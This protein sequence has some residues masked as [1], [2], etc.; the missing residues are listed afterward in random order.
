[1]C[2]IKKKIINLQLN[3]IR[4]LFKINN[5]LSTYLEF[6][7]CKFFFFNILQYF[8]LRVGVRV[9]PIYLD[10]DSKDLF[11]YTLNVEYKPSQNV[12]L[13]LESIIIGHLT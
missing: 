11:L 9:G 6:D 12:H 8:L 7:F 3:Y 10:F 5:I 13:L 4:S 2:N 1:M